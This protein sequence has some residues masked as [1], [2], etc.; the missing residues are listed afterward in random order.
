MSTSSSSDGNGGIGTEKEM[1][2]GFLEESLLLKHKFNDCRVLVKFIVD[3]LAQ[4]NNNNNN[5]NNCNIKSHNYF[6]LKR[7]EFTMFKNLQ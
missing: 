4:N 3:N 7:Q 5:K 6:D 2:G 1:K